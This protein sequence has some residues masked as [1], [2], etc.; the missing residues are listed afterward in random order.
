MNGEHESRD[1]EPVVA[2]FDPGMSKHQS[3]RAESSR[4]ES[5]RAESLD[6]SSDRS[7]QVT[8]ADQVKS[9]ERVQRQEPNHVK[10]LD[11][12]R[13]YDEG[14]PAGTQEGGGQ[15]SGA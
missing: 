9:L 3:S 1:E 14:G 5:S 11:L 6:L 15:G 10:S 13:D 4:V 8:W 2:A 12:S 7:S